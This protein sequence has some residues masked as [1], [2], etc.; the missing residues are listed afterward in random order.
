MSYTLML[1]SKPSFMQNVTAHVDVYANLFYGLFLSISKAH[2]QEG[3]MVHWVMEINKDGSIVVKGPNYADDMKQSVEDQNQKFMERMRAKSTF[4]LTTNIGIAIHQS[5]GCMECN[6]HNLYPSSVIRIAPPELG[7][8]LRHLFKDDVQSDMDIE[9][10]N[11]FLTQ[12]WECCV[13][14][15]NDIKQWSDFDPHFHAMR[16]QLMK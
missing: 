14:T 2:I 9:T 5:G 7:K 3:L 1:K 6:L 4:A 15:R 8:Y 10:N 11:A 13:N 16:V 12:F